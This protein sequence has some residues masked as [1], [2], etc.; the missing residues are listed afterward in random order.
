[1]D[2]DRFLER[3]LR[4]CAEPS[5]ANYLD[6][7]DPEATLSTPAW[8]A[9]PRRRNPRASTESTAASRARLPHDAG[10]LA[11]ARRRRSSSRQLPAIAAPAAR[12]GARSMHRST[13]TACCLRRDGCDRRP[14]AERLDPALPARRR[15]LAALG[16]SAAGRGAASLPPRLI[17]RR[18]SSASAASLTRHRAAGRGEDAL[19]FVGGA[20]GGHASEDFS[21]DV[22][23]R[24]DLVA[25]QHDRA[26]STRSRSRRAS[27][28][29]REAGRCAERA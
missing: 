11:R 1:M 24:V 22:A 9:R 16:R 12:A 13:A 4:F 20:R 25:A 18:S 14:L 27:P 2:G 17:A 15:R 10:T 8:P 29:R 5:V 21:I 23:E 6:L 3:F 7:F 28:R 19:R 26:T